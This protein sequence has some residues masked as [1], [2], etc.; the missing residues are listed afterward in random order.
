MG[1]GVVV[2][3]TRVDGRR[4]RYAVA[5]D[6]PALVLLHGLGRSIEDWFPVQELLRDAYRTYSVDLP[7]FGESERLGSLTDLPSLASA[8]DG[9]LDVL[10][11]TE[12]LDVSEPVRIAGNS[13]GGAVALR[14]AADRPERVGA[15]ILVDSA[16]FGR[17]VT[18]G[19]RV[20]AIPGL[21]RLLLRPSRMT[22]PVRARSVF[23]NRS[24]ATPERIALQYRLASRPHA[25]DV[26]LE[27][28]RALGDWRGVRLD[29]AR[30]LTGR[31]RSLGIPIL[32]CWGT[33]DRILPARQLEAARGA[34]PDAEVHL[35]ERVGHMPQLE[36]PAEFAEVVRDFLARTSAGRSGQ[37]G[38]A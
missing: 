32:L 8:V 25:A 33:H 10:A 3:E 11:D 4:I 1:S 21:G 6:G 17:E 38:Q 23:Y 34:F 30:E 36:S 18:A 5:G 31:V 29:W 35:F 26:F 2:R 9:F 13:L 16:G 12:P 24:L 14:F 28:S 19:L 22:A 37:P 15:L 27:T 20:L 7:G